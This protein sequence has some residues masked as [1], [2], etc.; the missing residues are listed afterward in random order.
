MD[1]KKTQ[2]FD[3]HV[4]WGARMT[5]FAGFAMPIQYP[6][7][8]IKEHHHARAHA[9]LFDISHMGQIRIDGGSAAR[10]LE[11]LVPANLRGLSVG[12]QRYTMLTNE[13]GGILDDI[14][15]TNRD[16]HLFVVVNASRKAQDLSYLSTH[17]DC[18]VTALEDRALL[19]LQGPSAATV[20]ASFDPALA[21][22]PYM[23]AR[24]CTLEG[25]QCLVSRCGYTGMD[26]FEISLPSHACVAV[27]ERLN[28]FPAVAPVGLGAR[29]SLRL[30]A[31]LCL[32]GQDLDESTTPVEAGLSWTMGRGRSGGFPGDAII[33]EQRAAGSA[34]CRVGLRPDSRAPLRAGAELKNGDGVQVGIITSG[35][36]GPTVGAPVAMGYVASSQSAPG[37]RLN[38]CLRGKQLEVIVTPLPFI[39]HTTKAKK[40]N[41]A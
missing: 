29:D 16:D 33:L 18:P 34:R 38:A 14:M 12:R 25:A 15:V 10:A 39:A 35:G 27:A 1:Q 32:Y 22:L 5:Q 3:L 24:L 37:T 17:L 13:E 7:G 28:A 41:H 8:I 31:G 40:R 2:L 6:G 20:M 26:G 19:A 11:A 9:A 30:E 23:T 36:F 4:Q 21:E